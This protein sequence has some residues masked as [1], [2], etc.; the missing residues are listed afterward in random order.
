MSW[1]EIRARANRV[2][3]TTFAREAT[4]TAPAEGSTP[5]PARIRLH[6]K[7]LRF[8][9][10]DR[11]GYAQVIDDVCEVRVDLGELVPERYGKI[12]F[13]GIRIYDIT[14]VVPDDSRGYWTCKVQP[15]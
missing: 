4:Y 12:D 11:E 14:E 3:H 6:D 10:L 7:F 5:V 15:T 1:G 2:V 9:D 8:G 13:Q